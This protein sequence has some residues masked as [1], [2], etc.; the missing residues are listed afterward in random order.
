VVQRRSYR[1]QSSGLTQ[2]ASTTHLILMHG[3]VRTMHL[4]PKSDWIRWASNAVAHRAVRCVGCSCAG[5][6]LWLNEDIELSALVQ[7]TNV[8]STQLRSPSY[9]DGPPPA[10]SPP[11]PQSSCAK[12]LRGKDALLVASGADGWKG[13]LADAGQC[14]AKCEAVGLAACQGWFYRADTKEC[15]LKPHA[16]ADSVTTPLDV[17]YGEQTMFISGSISVRKPNEPLDASYVRRRT[18]LQGITTPY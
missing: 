4:V 17:F 3:V 14:C 7:T 8:N 10:P 5:S 15:F 13:V 16:S 11:F 2:P 6:F 9:A 1:S 18:K 12:P